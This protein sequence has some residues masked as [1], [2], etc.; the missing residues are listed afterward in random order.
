L[1]LTITAEFL[2]GILISKLRMVVALATVVLIFTAYALLLYT[3]L[4][5]F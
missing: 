3:S 5:L 1:Q 2:A 4:R